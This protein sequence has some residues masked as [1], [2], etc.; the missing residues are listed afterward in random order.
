VENNFTKEDREMLIRIDERQQQFE[1]VM[2]NHLQHHFRYTILAW[3]LTL[4]ALVTLAIALLKV[5]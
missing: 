3:S 2:D 4:G 1:K 5:L